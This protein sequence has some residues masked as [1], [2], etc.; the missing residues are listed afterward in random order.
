MSKNDL[1][2]F[3]I[4]AKKNAYANIDGATEIIRYEKSGAIKIIVRKGDWE[5]TDKYVGSESFIGQEV[6]YQNGKPVWSMSYHG[7]VFAKDE[8]TKQKLV[9]FLKNALSNV[10]EESLFRGPRIHVDTEFTYI[11]TFHGELDFFNGEEMISKKSGNG[12]LYELRYHG[13]NIT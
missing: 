4:F 6:I 13:G 2:A 1:I 8:E 9:L 7:R 12:V 3:L 5:Y 11:N 10:S